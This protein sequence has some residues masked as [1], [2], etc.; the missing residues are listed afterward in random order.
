MAELHD[1]FQKLNEA[2]QDDATYFD[3]VEAVYQVQFH[4]DDAVY[5]IIVNEKDCK[6]VEGGN[7]KADCTL[8]FVKGDFEKALKGELNG[9]EAFMSGRLV[10]K[11]DKRLALKL[12]TYMSKHVAVT[13]S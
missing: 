13:R 1:L 11:G 7:R 8:I 12:Q 9:T 3:G 10:I 6:V 4:D 5:Q 2:L